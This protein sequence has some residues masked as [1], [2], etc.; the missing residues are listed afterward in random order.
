[1]SCLTA[2]DRIHG[3]GSQ[4]G[5]TACSASLSSRCEAM[6]STMRQ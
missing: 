5:I 6:P 2:I 1:M 4:R 3:G